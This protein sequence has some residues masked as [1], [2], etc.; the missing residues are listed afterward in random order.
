MPLNRRW[1][2]MDIF[3]SHENLNRTLPPATSTEDNRLKVG[4][5]H[6][7]HNHHHIHNHHKDNHKDHQH[8]EHHHFFSLRNPFRPR[9]ASGPKED[10]GG[11][12]SGVAGLLSLSSGGGSSSGGGH[13]GSG[14]NKEGEPPDPAS[15]SG[16][17][18]RIVIIQRDEK[19]YGFTV[20]GDNPVFVASVKAEGAASRAGVQQGDRILKVNGTLV[21][22]R[23]HM[24]VVKLIKSA[25]VGS[26]YLLISTPSFTPTP[27]HNPLQ[28]ENFYIN[29]ASMIPR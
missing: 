13:G 24:D 28:C 4:D 2:S 14:G 6:H 22:N 26:G 7:H 27:T 5:N 12:V 1:R 8:K 29:D 25:F 17:M 11:V 18:Q 16:L 9:L 3:G 21:T 19:G 15:N 23:N 10:S 20:S